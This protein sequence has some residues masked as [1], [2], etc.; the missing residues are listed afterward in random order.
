MSWEIAP[1][2]AAASPLGAVAPL[3]F[4]AEALP[5]GCCCTLRTMVLLRSTPRERAIRTFLSRA[6]VHDGDVLEESALVL[7]QSPIH[8][9]RLT[10]APNSEAGKCGS[11]LRRRVAKRPLSAVRVR[12]RAHALFFV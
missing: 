1:T 12:A 11:Y 4:S 5:G 8:H 3:T 6:R 2:V 10:Q 9:R 7:R